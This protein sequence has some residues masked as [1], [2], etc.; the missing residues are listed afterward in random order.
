[1]IYYKINYSSVR[2][3]I[4]VFPQVNDSIIPTTV[5]DPKFIN[6]YFLKK[7]PSDVLYPSPILRKGAKKTDLLSCSSQG[8]NTGLL[9]SNLLGNL[10]VNSSYYGL[11]FLQTTL[12]DKNDNSFEYTII[13]PY[14]SGYEYLDYTLCV[15]SIVS[16]F[17]KKITPIKIT[18]EQEL[19]HIS[20]QLPYGD[21]IYIDNIVML[22]TATTDFFMLKGVS[23]GGWGF[24]ISEKLKI[25]IENVGCTGIVFTEPNSRYPF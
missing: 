10:I 21:N 16:G 3:E 18:N 19:R 23:P 24:F 12:W 7:T 17:E 2:K 13:H 4:G 14:D 8:L 5:D 22:N 9:A 11:Q 25:A 20:S 1:M 6:Q 15:F